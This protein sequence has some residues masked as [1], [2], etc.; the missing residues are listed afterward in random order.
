MRN[1]PEFT[2]VQKPAFELLRDQLGYRYVPGE[3]LGDQRSSDS[4]VILMDVLAGRLRAINP[5]ITVNGIRDAAEAIRQP[6]A[7]NLMDA[8][9]ACYLYLS[10]WVTIDEHRHG[11]LVSPSIKFFDFENPENNDFLVVD[12]LTVKGPR[13]TRRLDLVIFVNGIPLVVIECKNPS[14]SDGITQAVEDL[15][16]YQSV[17]DGVARLFHTTLLTVALAKYDARYG[18]VATPLARYARWKSVFPRTKFDVERLLDR[19]PTVQDKLLIGMLSK[20][21]L[22]DLL[23]NFVVFDRDDGKVVK[24]LARYQ[25]FEAV[26]LTIGKIVGDAG[27]NEV[28]E[29]LKRYSVGDMEAP[30]SQP[31]SPKR[32]DGS[33]RGMGDLAK[34]NAASRDSSKAHDYADRGG[35]I[36][37]TQGSGKSLTM[38]WLCL[39]LKR[40]R[41][42]ENPTLLIVTDRMDLDRQITTTFLNCNFENPVRA[43]RVTHLKNLLSVGGGRTVM[44]TIQKFRD[45]VDAPEKK[46][47]DRVL[48]KDGNIF[49]LID[50]A[51]RTEYGQFN[52][53]LRAALPNACLI[54]F[55]GTPIPKTLQHFGGYIHRYTMPQSV[56]DGSTV[57]ILYESRIAD[58]EFDVA[59]WGSKTPADFSEADAKELANRNRSLIKF[60]EEK[61]RIAAIC[62]DIAQHYR[63]NFEADGFKAQIAVC[64]QRAASMYYDNL[65]ELMGKRIAV[66]ISGT[67]DKSSPLND[68]RDQFTPEEDWIEKLKTSGTDELAM[69][70]VVDKYLTGFDAPIV[71]AL[72]LD[73]PLAEHNLLQA[74]ARV[75]RPMPEKGKEWGLV[76]DYWGVAK[77]LNE[78][79][80]LLSIDIQPDDAMKPRGGKASVERLRQTRDDAFDLFDADWDREDIEPWIL[81]LEKE[82]IRA[83][84][85]FR[86]RE[87]YRALEQILPEPR[88]LRFVRDFAW[89]ERVKKEAREFYQEADDSSASPIAE[90]VRQRIEESL[91]SK[92]VDVLLSPVHILDDQFTAELDKL[93]SNRAKASR[94]EHKLKKTITIKMHEDPAFYSSL[95]DR[96]ADIIDEHRANRISDVLALQKYEEVRTTMREGQSESAE[97]LGLDANS[98]AVY[99]LLG[100]RMAGSDMKQED[101]VDLAAVIYETLQSEA[102][103]DWI[104]KEDVQREMRRK[105]KRQLRL[106]KCPKERIEELTMEIMDWARTG[107]TIRTES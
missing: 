44:A 49:V 19:E 22:L 23:R 10:R 14:D 73:K 9:E 84:F 4:D 85:K 24:K 1:G 34:R 68:L 62:K 81:R 13:K 107:I 76:V 80:A 2:D 96:I 37:H 64:S 78:A 71:R 58:L 7:R 3:E 18:S 39:K 32:G 70:I 82:D 54:G 95:E 31:L 100:K 8:N 61:K 88:A 57:P 66:L 69:L 16:A 105:I 51:H 50:E 77:H 20:P 26:N 60:G 91:F 94:M 72:Y 99:G 30:H 27:S 89:I 86:H 98:F 53:N 87:F 92:G 36:W 15:T 25:Q 93:N 29:K 104:S 75:N 41:E 21:T 83:V 101:I 11:K 63:E 102:V 55:T 90:R 38:L 106:A 103:L 74:I 79:L 48:S 65:T 35:V 33:Q 59:I 12:E 52:A 47:K 42:L 17:D 40:Q 67:K 56:A 28:R 97:T 43:S 5:G 46:P 6:L 45:E